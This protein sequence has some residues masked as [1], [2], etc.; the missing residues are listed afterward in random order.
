VVKIRNLVIIAA[1]IAA[2]LAAGTQAKDIE[3]GDKFLWSCYMICFPVARDFGGYKD[4]PL[5]RPPAEGTHP[6][7][8]DLRNAIDAGVDAFSVDLFLEDKTAK[9][10][11]GQL[12]K[13]INDNRLPFYLSPMFDGFG[14]PGVTASDVVAKVQGWFEEFAQEPC[15]ARF[16]GRPVI[17]TFGA[18]ELKPE[19]WREAL[20]R[21][22]AAGC[23]GY[24]IVEMGRIVRPP[25]LDLHL[26]KPW[27]DLFPAAD[28]FHVYDAQRFEGVDAAYRNAYSS[29]AHQ[30]VGDVNVGYWRPEI[31]VYASQ[32]GTRQFRQTWRMVSESPTTWVQQST[33]N[34]FSEN[35]H[36]MPSENNATTFTELN[37]YLA[38]QWK[39]K[40]ES[41]DAPR[42][43]LSQQ[44]EVL[45]GEE[46]VFELL[47][48]LRPQDVPAYVDL[49]IGDAEGQCVKTFEP[50]RLPASGLQA[51]E[52]RMSVAGLPSGQLLF[53]E[54]RLLDR[55]GKP[56]LTVRG[57]YTVVFPGGYRPERNYS[58]L[59][60]PAHR[61]ISGVTCAMTL[62]GRNG[63]SMPQSQT[64]GSVSLVVDSPV[65][66]ADG[67]IVHDGVQVL[68]LR[69]QKASLTLPLKWEGQIPI[70][71]QGR[72]DW[73]G[74]AL[75]AVTV[76]GRMATSRPVF[77]VRPIEA[78]LAIGLWTFDDDKGREVF[79]SSP[80][81]HDGRRGG[82][83]REDAWCPQHVPDRWGG[84][85]LRFDGVDDRMLL[86][87]PI[88]PPNAYTIECWAK[89]AATADTSPKGQIIFATASAAVVLGLQR[90]GAL[91]LTRMAGDQR[92]TVTDKEPLARNRWQHVAATYDGM[93]LRLYRDGQLVGEK[94]AVGVARCG[95]IGVGYNPVT[96]DSFYGGD[97]DELRLS[98]GAL[99]P[100]EF[101]PHNPFQYPAQAIDQSSLPNTN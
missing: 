23:D 35:H 42:L 30:W 48:L 53:P 91:S 96:H 40:P 20:D 4:R 90:N 26:A 76:D 55:A 54:G 24:W 70:N 5:D 74:Y 100:A 84:Q 29:P 32:E 17:F 8:V 83:Q 6:R 43:Y 69:H 12:V 73:G 98:A 41:L 1:L 65:E 80:W 99:A 78:E 81:L 56:A 49:R 82:R 28:V 86:D 33:W 67:E 7:L 58:W 27:L 37:R 9:A 16:E 3:R 87:G 47:S 2:A 89:P 79:D 10:G 50:V 25:S 51:A 95:Q 36:L 60:T 19:Q 38:A 52:F 72:L 64:Q 71:R 13:L 59:H 15:V 101:G 97:L 31:A 34:D 92:Y 18:S 66:L 45:V 85:C 57:P 22:H 93:Q 46:A 14:R 44:Q 21:L 77:V 61:Q 75:R 94:A 68:S 62:D 88:V 39:G 11:F 63:G